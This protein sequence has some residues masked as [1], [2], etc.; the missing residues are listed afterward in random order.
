MRAVRWVAL[1][2]GVVLAGAALGFVA[3]LL[4]P[5]RYAA[6]ATPLPMSPR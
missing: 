6:S 1:G 3:S 2:I 5:R 4:R